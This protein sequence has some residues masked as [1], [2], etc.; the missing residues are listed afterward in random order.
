M[1]KGAITKEI[2][3]NFRLFLTTFSY[4][5]INSIVPLHQEHR[6][7]FSNFPISKVIK[8][9]YYSICSNMI[10]DEEYN[11]F[12]KEKIFGDKKT[13]LI[14]YPL[15]YKGAYVLRSQF[16]FWLA[17]TTFRHLKYKGKDI[18]NFEDMFPIL[19]EYRDGFKDGFENFEKECI[20]KFFP[21][22]PDKSDYIERVFEYLTKNIP[23]TGSWGN[24]SPGFTTNFY[25]EIINLKEY[26]IVQGYYYKAW[27]IL[28][29]NHILFGDLFEKQYK[30]NN[31]LIKEFKND[32][33]NIEI[34]EIELKIRKI[35]SEKLDIKIYNETVSQNIKEKVSAR[36]DS[37]IKKYPINSNGYYDKLENKLEF[38]DLMECCEIIINKKNW[39]LFQEYFKNKNNLT[40]KFN[41]LSEL[42]NC[43]R[44]SRELNE[45]I[46]YEGR[47]S[48]IWFQKIIE[49]NEK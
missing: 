37:H 47:A 8:E 43:I 33:I 45:I 4:G 28:L 49:Q 42:R 25:N 35:I 3:D 1:F 23:I 48:I 27:S 20:T 44:H 13:F 31:V 12:I 7:L 15:I 10:S 22:F 11:G 41:K 2:L 16:H 14:P 5:D 6:F 9:Y 39:T 17:Q 29:S 32:E 36:I 30:A 21:M 38:F 24:S 34:E 18:K 19:E 46:I 26:G 40:E